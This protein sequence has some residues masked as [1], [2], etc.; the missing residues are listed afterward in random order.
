MTGPPALSI[1]VEF[2]GSSVTSSSMDWVSGS[3]M[4]GMKSETTRA[5]AETH[6]PTMTRSRWVSSW[7]R[8]I[9]IRSG[10]PGG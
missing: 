8:A 1:L 10:V 7:A 3:L 4:L 2:L 6:M 9:A 5:V